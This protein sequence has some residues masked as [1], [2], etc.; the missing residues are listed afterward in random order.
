MKRNKHILF[1]MRTY[2]VFTLLI[3][4]AACS[5]KNEAIEITELESANTIE[6]AYNLSELQFTS[7]DMKLGK[8]EMQDFHQVIKANGMI[9]VPPQSHVSVIS[10]F[11]GYVKDVK[12]LP[13]QWVKKGQT[14]FI[15]ENPDYV[16]TQ[17]AFLET[18]GQL[19]YLKSDYERQK[20][21]AADNITS[22]KIYLKAESEY[23]VTKVKYEALRKK[24]NLMDIDANTLSVENIITSVAVRAPING[25]ITEVHINQGAFLNPSD[26]AVTLINTEHMHLEL[27]VFEKD[28]S[29]IAVGQRIQF[30]IQ[31]DESATYEA[32]VHMI[33]KN[34]DVEKRTI[35][36]HG[37]L[38]DEKSTNKFIPGMYLE[39][40]IYATSDSTLSLPEEA[41][42]EVE[43]KYYVLAKINSS[44]NP[45]SFDKKEVKVGK[46]N[47]GFVEILNSSDFDEETEFLVKGAFNL[48]NE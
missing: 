37:H 4:L 34:V 6:N 20:L 25:Y 38:K 28:L 32:S 30:K 40:D 17:Q 33:N 1:K 24:L 41:L 45:Y 2:L 11:G 44:S 10:Y 35:N 42:V 26:V 21:L 5:T 43:E 22:Q 16:Q 31:D 29:K 27:N 13:G 3:S 47:N 46:S 15:L 7:S 48:I 36:I 9:D 8:L 39:A 18:Q 23:I 14:L 19:T 12:L